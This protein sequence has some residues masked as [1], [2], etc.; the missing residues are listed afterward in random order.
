M[1]R[2]R[3]TT[4]AL[5]LAAIGC[6][7]GV[8]T[9]PVIH[10]EETI[11]TPVDVTGGQDIGAADERDV[12]V[13]VAEDVVSD[14]GVPDQSLPDEGTLE[15][16]D[17]VADEASPEPEDIAEE[18]AELP[19]DPGEVTP[20]PDDIAPDPVPDEAGEVDVP[21]PPDPGPEADVCVPNCS[22]HEC[23]PDG[24]GSTCGDCTGG[25]VC[26]S[27]TCQCGPMDH[28]ACCGNAVCWFDSCGNPG[29]KVIDC[30]KGCADG[31]C[32]SCVPHCNGK[33][34]G[35]DGCGHSCG[36]CGPGRCDGMNWVPPDTCV[37]GQCQ[38]SVA[39]DCRDHQPCTAD[40]CDPSAGCGHAPLADGML[41]GPANC[42]GLLWQ[43]PATCVGGQC[44]NPSWVD[45]DDGLW[46]TTDSCVPASGCSNAVLLD[47]CLIDGVCRSAGDSGAACLKCD[48]NSSQLTWTCATSAT[49]DDGNLTTTGDQ[50]VVDPSVGCTCR[51]RP[52]NTDPCGPD[53]NP[54]CSTLPCVLGDSGQGRCASD[55]TGGGCACAQAPGCVAPKDCLGLVW[56]TFCGINSPGGH[57][58]CKGGQCTAVCGTPCGDGTCDPAVGESVWACPGDCPDPCGGSNPTCSPDACTM[59]DNRA[60]TCGQTT[61]V[62]WCQASIGG[63]G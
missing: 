60:G 51:G 43:G 2:S 29:V 21:N 42:S 58:D 63:G 54:T 33:A 32:I 15:T 22:G 26:I 41:C 3:L 31:A 7:G 38:P 39:V 53:L 59:Y 46:C 13:E 25:K 9:T 45:C 27:A 4:V 12:P 28:K 50:C 57:W 62:C 23:G 40:S 55:T 48:P 8:T 30:V 11:T 18:P 24:C 20:E 34:C 56:T 16:I 10:V 52:P 5:V 14:P 1:S 37:G 47:R 19:P 6:G 35:D 49:C 17:L 44:T 36:D 61:L